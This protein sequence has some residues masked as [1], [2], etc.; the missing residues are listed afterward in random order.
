MVLRIGEVEEGFAR[1]VFQGCGVDIS[2][3]LECGK[4]SGGCSTGHLM[5]YTP[6]QVIQL[7]KLGQEDALLGCDALWVCVAC[8]LCADRCPSAIDI[9]RLYDWARE[10]AWRRN[11]APPRPQVRLFH[12][13]M[14]GEIAARGRV[15]ELSL[16][17]R[18]NLRSRQYLKD[19]GLGRRMAFKGKLNPF[20]PRVRAVRLLRR[21]IARTGPGRD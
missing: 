14:L 15:S 18:F 9:P 7:V 17:V 13:L 21:M 5:D 12:E 19:A 20:V 8:H 11:V 16:A 3:C 2:R 6:R 1:R 4:C 10:Q